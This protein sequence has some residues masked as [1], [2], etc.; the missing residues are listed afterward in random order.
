M[1][2]G[3]G[4]IPLDPPLGLP[5]GGYIDRTGVSQDV[6]DPLQ[7]QAF[8]LEEG[9]RSLALVV[10]DLLGIPDGLVLDSEGVDFVIPVA[11]HTHSGPRPELV[12][13]RLADA[14]SA[15]ISLAR[16]DLDEVIRVEVKRFPVRDVC[17]RRDIPDPHPL[18][19]GIVL[20]HRRK[21]API[22]LLVFPCHPTV[23][24]PD[25]L[26]YSGDLAACIRRKLT[27]RSAGTAIYLNSC[28]GNISTH[29]TR[30][31]RTARE[32]ERLAEEFL[33]QLPPGPGGYTDFRP[34]NWWTSKIRLPLRPR[35]AVSPVDERAL[36]GVRLARRR[37]LAPLDRLRVAVLAL[38]QAGDLALLCLPFEV[39]YCTCQEI[40]ELL[41][42]AFPEPFVVGYAL[43]YRP[44]IVPRG[45]E[46]SYEWFASIYG[47]EA[48]EMLL[49]AIRRL[50][51]EATGNRA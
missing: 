9:R 28:A 24:G 36:P 44:Y 4:Q 26:A 35:P 11:T 7:V 19:A 17:S 1:K 29:Y 33:S 3:V 40:L 13:E 25:N 2:A 47:P 31:A 8:L 30:K 23:L 5:M 18:E 49:A 22:S 45:H 16:R 15:A 43:A 6:L 37:E 41:R 39:F 10:V 38:V 42:T 20:W 50:L 46:G 51:W 34:L 32:I 14:G 27:E 48:E 12:R 21:R